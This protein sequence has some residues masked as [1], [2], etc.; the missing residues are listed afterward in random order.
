M[1]FDMDMCDM[2]VYKRR[3]RRNKGFMCQLDSIAN[4]R[5]LFLKI[6]LK[7]SACL[8]CE[9]KNEIGFHF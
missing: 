2:E 9:N 7:P 6:D 3:I 4:V 1:K 8:W 5:I